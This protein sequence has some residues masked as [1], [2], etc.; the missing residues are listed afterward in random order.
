MDH[1]SNRIAQTLGPGLRRTDTQA[2]VLAFFENRFQVVPDVSALAGR[3]Q[4]D[5]TRMSAGLATWVPRMQVPSGLVRVVGTAGSGK[6]QL[7]LRP[8][9]TPEACEKAAS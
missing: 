8:T 2:R 9:T 7:A 6:T 4:Q 5:A 1:I 3:L